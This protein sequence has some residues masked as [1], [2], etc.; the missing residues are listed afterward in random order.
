MK[1]RIIL[2]IG[3]VAVLIVILF[4]FSSKKTQAPASPTPM[5]EGQPP[6]GNPSQ[7]PAGT[8]VAPN[9]QPKSAPATY[10]KNIITF[11]SPSANEQWIFGQ[12]NKIAWNNPAG[13]S[14]SLSLLDGQTK[15][16]V[17]FINVTLGPNQTSYTWDTTSVALSRT[18]P[19]KKDIAPGTYIAKLAF[20]GPIASL[21]SAPFKVI[22]P[23]QA[24]TPTVSFQIANFTFIPKTLSAKKGTQVTFTNNDNVTLTIKLQSH[25]PYVVAPGG[26]FMIDT[27]TLT[28]GTY[29][30]YSDS[31]PTLNANLTVTQ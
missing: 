29:N 8:A 15:A 2:V 11:S 19:A 6:A 18:N 30:F 13:I 28:P 20:D 23:A 12:N 27:N 3:V 26:S 25:S 7:A 10:G 5:A 1:I 16:V 31:Y 9:A 22:Y 21:Q 4:S 17:G 14:G 24:Q